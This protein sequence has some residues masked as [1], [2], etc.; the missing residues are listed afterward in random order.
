MELGAAERENLRLQPFLNASASNL[1]DQPTLGA[2]PIATTENRR[3]YGTL[4]HQGPGRSQIY[5]VAADTKM[6]A[7]VKCCAGLTEGVWG[8]TSNSLEGV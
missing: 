6:G 4:L 5:S 8:S 7:D 1:N 3:L 2:P